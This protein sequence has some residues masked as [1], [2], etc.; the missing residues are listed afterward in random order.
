MENL[1]YTL[2]HNQTYCIHVLQ[3]LEIIPRIQVTFKNTPD[4]T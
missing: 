4:K 1:K 2:R 3:Y